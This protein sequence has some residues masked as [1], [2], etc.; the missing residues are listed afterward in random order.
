M[1]KKRSSSVERAFR[2]LEEVGTSDR[3]SGL[4]FTEVKRELGRRHPI[5]SSTLS[6]LLHTLNRLGYL[7]FDEKT[8]L[9]SL[10]HRLINL[11]ETADKRLRGQPRDEKCMDLLKGVVEKTNCGAHI[12]ILDSGEALY[13]LREEAAGFF[14]ARISPGKTQ[15]P[16]FTAIGKA[17]ICWFDDEQLQEILDLHQK[18]KNVTPNSLTTLEQLKPDLQ[19][20][21]EKEYAIDNEEHQLGVRC[22]AAPIYAGPGKV[23]ASI[24][25]S[26]KKEDF[27]LEQLSQIG[28]KILKPAAK[29]ATST[30]AI[31]NALKRHYAM[32]NNHRNS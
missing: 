9:H 14:G 15:V 7:Q 8:R 10:G 13:L 16:H 3:P 17:L 1:T 6:N 26:T 18:P 25:I 32:R 30:P 4:S 31:I 2:I 29:E 19:T 27:S 5:P 20:I 22:V 24:G 23:I 11:G 12:A 21:K 28:E